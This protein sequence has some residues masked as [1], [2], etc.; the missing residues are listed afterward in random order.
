M[1]IELPKVQLPAFKFTWQLPAQPNTLERV[2]ARATQTAYAAVTAFE[3][4][5]QSFDYLRR[6]GNRELSVPY[7]VP[8]LAMS[9]GF[10]ESGRGP[11]LHH[12]L[13]ADS[14][15]L[16]YQ[17]STPLNWLASPRDCHSALGAI[18]MALLNTP[19]LEEFSEADDFT[20]IDLLRTIRSFDP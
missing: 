2:R 16:N 17:L 10:W 3:M 6:P 13:I 15:L 1:E 9:V 7:K 8:K 11:A 5:L 19:I 4:L 20:G 18:E 14:K 12:L